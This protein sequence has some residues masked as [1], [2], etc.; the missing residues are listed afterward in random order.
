MIVKI[1]LLTGREIEVDALPDD[2]VLSLKQKIQKEESFPP[3]Q[4]KLVYAGKVMA[5]DDDKLSDYRIAPNSVVHMIVA[6]RGG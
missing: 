3:A 4:Q 6:L 1:K 2:T 5:N